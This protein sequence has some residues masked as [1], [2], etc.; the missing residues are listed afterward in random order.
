[1]TETHPDEDRRSSPRTW[2]WLGLGLI[3]LVLFLVWLQNR[4]RHDATD[5]D[6]LVLAAMNGTA[7]DV[8]KFLDRGGDPNMR[9]LHDSAD[10]FLDLI[11][12]EITQTRVMRYEGR[13]LEFAS[14]NKEH[15]YEVVKLLLDRGASLH[16]GTPPFMISPL[17][18]PA[19]KGDRATVKLLIDHGA[20]INPSLRGSFSTL[21]GA[22]ISGDAELVRY[23]LSKGAD[24]KHSD[25]NNVIGLDRPGLSKVTIE[26]IRKMLIAAGMRPPKK[27][28]R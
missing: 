23:L 10:G 16:P 2:I 24:A 6:P 22:A 21:E 8:A 13:L 17:F 1:M 3:V 27:R 7:A 9:V 14:M 28:P 26:E 11:R 18:E 12:R 4:P 19:R 20:D 5:R 15:R 25:M